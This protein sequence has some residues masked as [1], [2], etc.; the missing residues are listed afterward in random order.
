MEPAIEPAA[1]AKSGTGLSVVE[2]EIRGHLLIFFARKVR[3]NAY[4]VRKP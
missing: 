4:R 3:L 1:N 2:Q